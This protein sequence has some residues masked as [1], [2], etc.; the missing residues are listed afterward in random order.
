MLDFA[1]SSSQTAPSSPSASHPDILPTRANLKPY[2][3]A[4][5]A[6]PHLLSRHT[7]SAISKLSSPPGGRVLGLPSSK[8]EVEGEVHSCAPLTPG[9][10]YTLW[11]ALGAR[12]GCKLC[13]RL[14]CP[15]RARTRGRGRPV[16]WHGTLPPR[17]WYWTCGE[18]TRGL[19]WRF[20]GG[21]SCSP[22]NP[23]RDGW[24]CLL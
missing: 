16:V 15:A 21:C 13:Q 2:Y 22:S 12:R 4:P 10:C 18:P 11:R 24:N 5:V 17:R 20:R 19:C 23:P 14:S 7:R 1:V 6:R 9:A 3:Y 8:G